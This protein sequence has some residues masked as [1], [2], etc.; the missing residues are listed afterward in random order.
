METYEPANIL[1]SKN[2]KSDENEED[3]ICDSGDHF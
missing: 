1:I 2:F 3:S